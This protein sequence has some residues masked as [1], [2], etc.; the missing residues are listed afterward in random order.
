M[1]CGGGG[2]RNHLNGNMKSSIFFTI[3]PMIPQTEEDY[4]TY[5]P[6]GQLCKIT[7]HSAKVSR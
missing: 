7:T 4:V 2:R 5:R 3:G 6:L 1:G